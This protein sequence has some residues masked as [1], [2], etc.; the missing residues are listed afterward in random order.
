MPLA[1]VGI[2]VKSRLDWGIAE[3]GVGQSQG[4]T[5]RASFYRVIFTL[6]SNPDARFILLDC[7]VTHNRRQ[8]QTSFSMKKD[9]F[10][11]L[12]CRYIM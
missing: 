10:L 1:D 4:N 6:L 8:N 12:Y 11:T 2:F 5:S 9:L 7:G 3:P